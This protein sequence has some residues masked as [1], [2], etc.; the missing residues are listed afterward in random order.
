MCLRLNVAAPRTLNTAI[1]S[2]LYLTAV[3]STN[4]TAR[5]NNIKILTKYNTYKTRITYEPK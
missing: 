4:I 3:D 1:Y 5:I 2:C